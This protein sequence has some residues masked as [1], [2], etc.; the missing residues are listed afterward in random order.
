MRPGALPFEWDGEALIPRKGFAR[1]ADAMFVIGQTYVMSE[2][3]ERSSASHNHQFAWIKEAWA[4]LPEHLA[5]QFPTEKILR[6]HA[7]CRAGYCTVE[8]IACASNAEAMRQ[9]ATVRRFADEYRLV[10]VKGNVVTVLTAKSQSVRAM[11][12]KTFQDSKQK[13]LDII[14]D[15]IGVTPQMLAQQGEAA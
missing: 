3:Q 5:E 12:A 8:Q 4:S 13:V 11:G 9:A 1:R 10:T 7:L 6:K 2:E 15:L 14:A